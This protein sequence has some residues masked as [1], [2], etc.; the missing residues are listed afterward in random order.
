M[1][2]HHPSSLP[3]HRAASCCP[4]PGSQNFCHG[5]HH[6]T[7][8]HPGHVLL[9]LEFHAPDVPAGAEQEHH[10]HLPRHAQPRP[11]P[12]SVVVHDGK[13]P[14]WPCRGH[15]LH[16]HC[17]VDPRVWA[18]CLRLLRWLPSHVDGV[19]LCCVC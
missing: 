2:R 17:H 12:N 19:L 10:H 3:L 18:A 15:G 8:V 11:T 7:L 6:L 1:C 13:A 5:R 4:W 16:G 14:A 9:R